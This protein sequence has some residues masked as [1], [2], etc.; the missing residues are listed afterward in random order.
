MYNFID[1]NYWFADD[2]KMYSKIAEV[3]NNILG[4][5]YG[6]LENVKLPVDIR[7]IVKSFS[8]E[9][10][11]T[12]LYTLFDRKERNY[13]FLERT[14]RN[15]KEEWMIFINYDDS[16]FDKRYYLAIGFCHYLLITEGDEKVEHNQYYI[17]DYPTNKN[18]DKNQF[19]ANT[20]AA[21]L[22]CPYWLIPD[23]MK[24]IK[25]LYEEKGYYYDGYDHGYSSKLSKDIAVLSHKLFIPKI[26]A[27]FCYEMIQR[28]NDML[29]QKEQHEEYYKE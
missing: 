1:S 25:E 9:I 6:G 20:M 10:V 22:L 13:G 28:Y 24:I 29:L 21:F 19:I 4:D 27:V 2:F 14:K 26:Y 7:G 18:H 15:G 17:Y 16:E 5:F 23:Q 3:T 11:S 12:Y 8:I